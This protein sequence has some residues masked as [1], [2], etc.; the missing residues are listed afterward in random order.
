MYTYFLK[1]HHHP[2]GNSVNTVRMNSSKQ[3]L[4][5]RRA[6]LILQTEKYHIEYKSQRESLKEILTE[7]TV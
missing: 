4:L 2:G 5:L 1:Y 7:I 6:A 3:S